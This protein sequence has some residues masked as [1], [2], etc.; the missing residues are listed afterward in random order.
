[1]VINTT[2]EIINTGIGGLKIKINK[3]V[4]DKRG[5]LCEILPDGINNNFLKNKIGNI[6]A[7]IATGREARAGHYHFKNIENF[8]TLSGTALWIFK[9]FRNESPTFGKIYCVIL[10]FD[11]IKTENIN[12]FT[13]DSSK[14]AQVTVPAGVYHVFCPLTEKPVTVLAIAS[15]PHNDK[16]YV[17]IN[18]EEIPEIKN[19][20][21]KIRHGNKF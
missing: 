4:P 13:I 21:E 2:E 1:M 9:D 14:M 19:I 7:S 6:Y 10:G 20:I 3:V 12:S 11:D 17:R 5:A 18:P 8:Y 16:D 15:E